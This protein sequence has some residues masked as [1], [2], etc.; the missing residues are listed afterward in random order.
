MR[1]DPTHSACLILI[2][3][4]TW[5]CADPISVPTTSIYDGP[6]NT[7]VD[8]VDCPSGTSCHPVLG[9]CAVP[10]PVSEREHVVKVVLDPDEQTIDIPSQFFQVDVRTTPAER[11]ELLI[12]SPVLLTVDVAWQ[13]PTP[14]VTSVDA[15]VFLTRT[16]INV[17]RQTAQVTSYRVVDD[18]L[19][20]Y[21][22]PGEYRLTI[23]PDN[24]AKYRPIYFDGLRLV[25]HSG[26]PHDSVLYD[27][28]STI[29]EVLEIP[30]PDDN[31]AIHGVVRLGD[32]P[33]DGLTVGAID[34]ET[35]RLVSTTAI[36][37]CPGEETAP[38]GEFTIGVDPGATQFSLH[39][40]R[41][42]EPQYPTTV[43]PG[44]S[45]DD[46]NFDLW[47]DP[48]GVPILYGAKVEGNS[49]A[50]RAPKCIAVFESEQID[51]TTLAVTRVEHSAQTNEAGQ[52]EQNSGQLGIYLYPRIYTVTVIPTE[53]SS[54]T[55]TDYTSTSE[56]IDLSNPADIDLQGKVFQLSSRFQ[57]TGRVL[58][59]GTGVPST[60]LDAHPFAGASAFA[61]QNDA[62]S[63]P[64]GTFE[65][66]LDQGRYRMYAQ[67]PSESGYAW[68]QADLQVAGDGTLDVELPLPVVAELKLSSLETDGI[69]V[70]GAVVEWY[71]MQD[72]LGYLISRSVAGQDGTVHS[73]LPP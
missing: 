55:K 16:G 18:K 3:C 33:T 39:I 67:S 29:I 51:P 62:L 25:N 49:F 20:V 30:R 38:C 48:V 5:C 22:L 37:G 19:Q 6:K 63:A 36:T 7:C 45:P 71:E 46:E 10:Q 4:L 64:D 57:I 60:T 23:L 53:S 14:D 8:S 26:L 31:T 43:I 70:T 68:G 73:L 66:W 65:I 72:G 50:E 58:A 40:S 54:N 17:Y 56:T 41:P 35:N 2:S 15:R 9:L 27:S 42:D 11:S 52:L 28:T 21:V 59:E 12:R 44:F 47:L 34:P 32:Q 61:R 1:T 24:P 13:S 69:N